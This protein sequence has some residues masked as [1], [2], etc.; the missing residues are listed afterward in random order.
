MVTANAPYEGLAEILGEKAGVGSPISTE[1]DLINL[2]KKGLEKP[3]L[4][5]IA[6]QLGIPVAEALLLLGMPLDEFVE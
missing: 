3:V 1:W 5:I 4:R 2:S 6:A